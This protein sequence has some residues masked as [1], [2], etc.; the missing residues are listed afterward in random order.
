M[1]RKYK[2]RR[3]SNGWKSGRLP[4]APIRGQEGE[5]GRWRRRDGGL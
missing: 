4:P 5:T 2:G 1:L 3:Q